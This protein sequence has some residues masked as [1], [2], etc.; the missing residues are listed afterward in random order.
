MRLTGNHVLLVYHLFVRNYLGHLP[1][2]SS[3]LSSQVSVDMKNTVDWDTTLSYRNDIEYH[4]SQP[5][6]AVPCRHWCWWWSAAQH[7]LHVCTDRTWEP[8]TTR[9]DHCLVTGWH[10]TAPPNSN[11][12][13]V[14]THC[15]YLDIQSYDSISFYGE[16]PGI[17]TIGYLVKR[18]KV[19]RYGL[20]KKCMVEFLST[21]GIVSTHVWVSTD[22]HRADYI[23]YFTLYFE[24]DTF[25][26]FPSDINKIKKKYDSAE[27]IR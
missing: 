18:L 8:W 4:S 13:S 9:P 11:H 27:R 22:Q 12:W 10:C 17:A 2:L 20:L 6:C 1:L 21:Q 16:A 5:N 26:C 14:P 19:W 7:W 15:G 23:T 24:D 3:W 25:L